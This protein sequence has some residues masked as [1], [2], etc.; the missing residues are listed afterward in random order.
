[1]PKPESTLTP[2]ELEV[3]VLIA[4]G[5]TSQRI[6]ETLDIAK[7][8]ANE[9]ALSIIDKLGASNRTHAVALA[10]GKHPYAGLRSPRLAAALFWVPAPG[11]G[12]AVLIRGRWRPA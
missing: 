1:M 7:R 10:I 4:G 5:Q 2:R 11:G 3:L 9:H 6:G 8:T 12:G